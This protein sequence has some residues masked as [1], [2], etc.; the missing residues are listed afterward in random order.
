ML[1]EGFR[2]ELSGGLENMMEEN[3]EI[4]EIE[5]STES[6][7]LEDSLDLINENSSE[8]FGSTLEDD[9]NEIKEESSSDNAFEF[10][11]IKLK[12]SD[13]LSAEQIKSLS[14]EFEKSGLRM[15]DYTRKTQELAEIRNEA[16]ELLALRDQVLQDPSLLSD[17]FSPEALAQAMPSQ[18][19][20]LLGLQ[21]AGIS[22]QAWNNALEY[23]EESGGLDQDSASMKAD[24]YANRFGTLENRLHQIENGW[25]NYQMQ[26]VQAV[27]EHQ[28]QAELSQ[29]DNEVQ[30]ALE[31]NEG[32]DRDQ[33]LLAIM[34]DRSNKSVDQIAKDLKGQLDGQV[35]NYLNR[36]GEKQR[37]RITKP[38]GTSVP[39]M[40]GR[41]NTFEEADGILDKLLESGRL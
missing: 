2:E 7:S 12:E 29:L 37:K 35:Q 1:K 28:K 4:N 40:P 39:I 17:Y 14:E 15:S 20:L 26:Q 24:P 25:R 27:Q 23:L 31:K 32:V 3:N 6:E 10:G 22:P 34:R 5:N 13:R 38:S 11:D 19:L 9:D 8:D 36:V 30:T 21:A 18:S 16:N 41:P 33:L